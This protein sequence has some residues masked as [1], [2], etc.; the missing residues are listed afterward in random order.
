MKRIAFFLLTFYCI[1]ACNNEIM[2]GP[3]IPS[4]GTKP[5][6]ELILPDAE[7]VNVYSTATTEENYI[8]SIW[9]IAFNGPSTSATK[10]WV[11]K[12][13][14][15]IARNG[16]A[17]QLLPQLKNTP[18]DGWRII[19]I[20]NVDPNPDTI[21]V[22]P[23]NINSCFKIVDNG[24]YYGTEHLPMYGEFIWSQISG[25]TC[26]MTRAVAKIQVQMGTSVSDATGNFTAQNVTYRLQNGGLA[27]FIQPSAIIQGVPQTTWV[28]SAER[29]LFIQNTAANEKETNIYLHEFP[30]NNMTGL[31][32]PV[33]ETAFD[34]ARQHIILYKHNATDDT[35]YYRLDFYNPVTKKF[36][37]T[38][39]NHHYIFTIN[40]VRSEG[41]LSEYEA[42]RN[43]GSN[44]EYEVRVDGDARRIISNGQYAMVLN[45]YVYELDT[46]EI[47]VG[48]GWSVQWPFGQ[49]KYQLPAGMSALPPGTANQITVVS[50]YGITLV[51]PSIKFTASYQD[52]Y[53]DVP[54]TLPW[55][56]LIHRETIG[57]VFL[58]LGNITHR[59]VLVITKNT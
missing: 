27:G 3:D 38:K 1:T 22:T 36:L 25:N 50:P 5:Q 47:V 57:E 29:Y 31:G 51:N 37:E 30:S 52:L 18:V 6:I 26:T 39:R 41:Y 11:E 59:L 40:K 33:S 45:P 46:V 35:T 53:F 4:N 13:T 58:R 24:Y 54:G 49:I 34:A 9:V 20:A 15:G 14:T 2:E 19:C 17:S 43:P 48:Q 21:S 55:F 10:Q 12:I 8:D 28:H 23:T 44:I 32:V 42:Q 16:H 7:K 56:S